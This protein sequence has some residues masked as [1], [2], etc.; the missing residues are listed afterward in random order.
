MKRGKLIGLFV[1]L[2]IVIFMLNSCSTAQN[3]APMIY[4]ANEGDGTIS[5]I[6]SKSF[7]VINTIELSGMPHNVN[8]DP[9]GRCNYLGKRKSNKFK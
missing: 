1:F 9:L 3:K 6:N 2:F 5:V 4:V 7:E 8:V